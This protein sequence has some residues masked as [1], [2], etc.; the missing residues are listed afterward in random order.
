MLK[1]S[2]TL[3]DVPLLRHRPS[4]SPDTFWVWVSRENVGK[5]QL[6]TMEVMTTLRELFATLNVK[7]WRCETQPTG[8]RLLHFTPLI[9]SSWEREDK[10]ARAAFRLFYLRR[11]WQR[12][13]F[14]CCLCLSP[15]KW[16]SGEK[17]ITWP[18]FSVVHMQKLSDPLSTCEAGYEG[19]NERDV[20]FVMISISEPKYGARAWID[21]LW[22]WMMLTMFAFQCSQLQ[23]N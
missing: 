22:I 20:L 16:Q 7:L 19:E 9:I 1:T 4:S 3:F 14:Y 18:N 21:V 5:R 10:R 8:T 12:A 15:P 11:S 13:S 2:K 17:T 23:E 6:I